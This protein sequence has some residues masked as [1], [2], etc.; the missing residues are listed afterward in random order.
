M[1]IYLTMIMMVVFSAGCNSI[2]YEE[3]IQTGVAGTQ[4]VL[5]VSALPTSTTTVSTKTTNTVEPTLENTATVIIPSE[6]HL[7]TES[8]VLYTSIGQQASCGD[9]MIAS[10]PFPPEFKKDLFEHHASGTFLMVK[11]ALINTTNQPI[12]IWDGDYTIKSSINGIIKTFKPH[13]AAT[14]YL[15]IQKGGRL[16]QDQVEPGVMNWET[17]L[18]FDVDPAGKDWVLVFKPGSEGGKALCELH[19]DLTT[20]E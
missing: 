18:A 20:S 13:R 15:F 19:F 2:P 12:Q 11:L 14:T 1:R 16:M 3:E 8:S 9:S 17:N 10:V 4:M 5:T 7:P 6:T